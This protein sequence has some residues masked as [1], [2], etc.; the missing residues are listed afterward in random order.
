MSIL[1]IELRCKLK[2][3]IIE[4]R[5]IAES[6]AKAALETLA[7]QH[8][9]PY[10]HMTPDQ[11][12]LRNHLRARARQLGDKQ[13]KSGKL[14]ITHLVWE[15]AYEHW[16]R[17]LFAR[18]LADNDLLIEPEMGVAVSLEECEELATEDGT[19]L[20]SLASSFAQQMLPKIFRPGNPVLQVT[21][22]RE[23]QG[24]LEQL[25]DDLQPEIF[26][27]SDALGWVYQF[28]Q[29]KRK[30]QVNKSGKKIGADELPAVTQLFTEPYMVHFLIHNTLGA[31]YAGK[32]LADNSHLARQAQ[33]EEKLRNAVALPGV[34]WDYLRFIRIEEGKGPWC[35]A[36]GIFEG[37]PT[38]AAELKIIDPCCG[39]GHFL[40]AML[41]HLV[42]IRIAEEGL[43]ARDACDAVLR[44][45]IH[46]LE[47]DERCT[48]IAAFALALAVWTYPG[49]GGYR[50][51]PEMR[52]ACSGIA[53]NTKRDDWTSLAGDN[54][55]LRNGMSQLYDL[56]QDAPTLGSLID[57]D[58]S[59]EKNLF[60]AGADELNSL[61]QKVMSTEKDD[62]EQYELGVAACG[63]ADAVKILGGRYHMV[64]TNVPYL[65]RGK[66][67]E[68][69]KEFCEQYY[70]EAKND[71]AT[72][73]LD[74]LLRL[75]SSIGT[76]VLV[77]PQ[78]WLFLVTYKNF[79]KRLLKTRRWD[80][81]AKL[82][83]GAFETISGEI[84]KVVLLVVSASASLEEQTFSG[85]DAADPRTVKEKAGLLRDAE[86]KTLVQREQLKNPDARV[87]LDKLARMKSLSH[88]T[89]AYAG[90]QSGDYPCY[91]RFFWELPVLL[92]G[93]VF[94]QSTVK[95][96]QLFG[97][98]EHVLLWEGGEGA[99]SQSPTSYI[100]G[101]DGWGKQGVAVSQ[102]SEI[103]VTLYEG[104]V[105]DNNTAVI[106]PHNPDHLPAIWCFCSSPEYYE[107]VRMIDKN[108]KV[109]NAT[110]A[111][112]PFG[113]EYWQSVAIEK[114][115][116]GLPKPYSDDP[117]QWIFHGYPA[118]SSSPLHVAVARLLG[119]RWP[120]EL[121][122]SMR[123]SVEVRE[124]VQQCKDLKDYTNSDGIVCIPAIRGED[125]A[126][127]RLH[128]LLI[129]AYGKEWATVKEQE[130]IAATGSQAKDLD[131]WLYNDF[132]EQH[133][134]LFYHR[135]FVWH[136]WDGRRRDGFHSLVNYHKLAETDG[137][138]RQLLE[139]LTYSYLG[140]WIIRQKDG[141]KRGED[142]AEGRLTAALELQKRLIAILE[143]EPP[144]DIFVRWKPIEQQPIG[145][146]PDINDGV[147]LNIRPFMAS[148][149][150]GGRKG[151]GILRW[152]PNIKW[153]KDR[154][155]EPVR[156]KGRFPWFWDNGD[157]TG[158]RVNNIH[159]TNKQKREARKKALRIEE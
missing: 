16:H 18:F 101:R 73:F 92:S 138:G 12:Q 154:G 6:G 3:T 114:Y 96:T 139:R 4:A 79:R 88:Y 78:N 85:I 62:Y 93:W 148:D 102:M 11:R 21:F 47:I 122:D 135:P 91:G 146:E 130:L 137:K 59:I 41:N 84:V 144:F 48:Q 8:Y 116:N 52:V 90:I 143:G 86:I 69:L 45:N 112:V 97:G 80:L 29:K 118:V 132:F 40:V 145:W 95:N 54:E 89:D 126:I 81:V 140:E 109:T 128:A 120:A 74:R 39:S 44:E 56:F 43:T 66:Q 30:E 108:L 13:E 134:K 65:A 31:W 75:N 123:L 106:V 115:P 28:W 150:P 121:D 1:P 58:I 50:P 35:P 129:A 17:M 25:L 113:L 15:C 153:N 131:E 152:K 124:L 55:R 72:V 133:C 46:G 37:W 7:V 156:S 87:S 53:P 19:D 157:F 158:E 141:V 119:Y 2:K 20:W 36:A 27:A 67:I 103:P 111:K 24:K 32:V 105:W 10:D 94:Q 82:G 64:I 49:G 151:A 26:K 70:N 117:T 14:E 100:R 142:G 33:N 71:L 68:T 149:I 57:P 23:Y 107:A 99:L 147:R 110:L 159:L 98:R 9:E 34:T 136:I 104:D 77:L 63:I 38:K 155:K 60:R 61:L 51:I 42:P 125:P 127:E 5:D 22:A 83:P 76:T